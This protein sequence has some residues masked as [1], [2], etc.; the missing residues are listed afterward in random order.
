MSQPKVYNVKDR[1]VP[2]DAVYIGRRGPWGNQYI[3]GVH[4]NRDEV[5]AKFKSF[6]EHNPWFVARVSRDLCGKSLVCHC[7]PLACHGD[8]LLEIANTL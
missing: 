6:C 1:D 2:Q 8:V 4:G 7:S 3:I 5:I